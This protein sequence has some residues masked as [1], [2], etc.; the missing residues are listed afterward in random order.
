MSLPLTPQAPLPRHEGPKQAAW[1]EYR[2]AWRAAVERWLA[3]DRPD[4]LAV[5]TSTLEE[6][7]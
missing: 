3:A 6:R 2:R 1:A 4:R 5:W 7:R